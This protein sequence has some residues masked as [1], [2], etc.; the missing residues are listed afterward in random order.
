MSFATTVRTDAVTRLLA[1]ATSA[2][3]RVYDSRR[4]PF[5]ASEPTRPTTQL[6]AI[7]VHTT[8]IKRNARGNK[9]GVVEE[10]V[11]LVVECFARD[12]GTEADIAET[13]DTLE[14]E[15]FAALWD[16]Q[17]WASQYVGSGLTVNTSTITRETE[18]SRV[19]YAVL[20]FDVTHRRTRTVPTG[21]EPLNTIKQAVS[22]HP[23]DEVKANAPL[24]ALDGEPT[25]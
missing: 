22:L 10:T 20:G 2:G 6:P 25:P 9:A 17:S 12:D 14:D 16:D 15:A 3:T 21:G 11:T 1:A 5:Q 19:G 8:Q 24:D 7:V 23:S 18:S 13:I 4:Q